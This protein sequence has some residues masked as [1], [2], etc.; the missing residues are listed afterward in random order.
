M[1][2]RFSVLSCTNVAN[3]TSYY[4]GTKYSYIMYKN[5][6]GINIDK[7]DEEKGDYKNGLE[8]SAEINEMSSGYF[9][10]ALF[11]LS[12][13]KN[14]H[15]ECRVSNLKY[16]CETFN[17]RKVVR[18]DNLLI[19]DI[20]TSNTFF[21]VGN[22][23]YPSR[24]SKLATNGIIIELP[25]GQVDITPNREELQYSQFTNDTIDKAC[26]SIQEMLKDLVQEKVKIASLHD[27]YEF[28]Q[29][30]NFRVTIGG[31][32]LSI[33]KPDYEGKTYNITIDGHVIP[34]GFDKFLDDIDYIYAD[35]DSI[36]KIL[37]ERRRFKNSISLRGV[38]CDAEKYTIKGD[39]ITKQVTLQYY[40]ENLVKD[41]VIFVQNGLESFKNK[42]TTQ[43]NARPRTYNVK[44]CIDFLFNHI[45][46][47]QISNN[48]VPNSFVEEYKS[49]FTTSKRT[50]DQKNLFSIRRYNEEGYRNCD[51][52]NLSLF[53]KYEAPSFA[54]YDSNTK[55]HDVLKDLARIFSHYTIYKKNSRVTPSVI[56]VKKTD[57]DVLKNRK[58]F[59][60]I[61]DFLY[62]RNNFLEKLVTAYLIL[63]QFQSVTSYQ[64]LRCKRYMEFRS[65]YHK[66][67][68]ALGG[69]YSNKTFDNIVE[70]YT[71]KGWYN[72]VD[73]AYYKLSERD[74]EILHELS[75]MDKFKDAVLEAVYYKLYGNN[76]QLG[77]TKP[78]DKNIYKIIKRL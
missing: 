68:S 6:G 20:L 8:V 4:N 55:E 11:L 47:G 26:L 28:T 59:V 66:Q 19:C 75:L 74:V 53:L 70:Y 57:I 72:K 49:R 45:P 41:T 10:E 12:M 58:K 33:R 3:I 69:C 73:V 25:M 30:Y 21:K 24:K 9:R 15:V 23:L 48:D 62:L 60:Y 38:L 31:L 42:I 29:S 76:E 63:N 2:G 32:D 16:I 1:I 64:L 46:I 17:N 37:S 44:E 39:S 78:K 61:N 36:Y 22:V 40:R 7:L 52:S 35:Q 5:N 27:Y 51:Y 77:I 54:V 65:K 67:L 43:L 50:I 14:L 56:T 13:F 34:K 18:K 71:K